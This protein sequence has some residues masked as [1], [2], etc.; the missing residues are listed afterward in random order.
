[1]L[2]TIDGFH[3]IGKSSIAKILAKELGIVYV[4]SGLI[5]RKFA[6][7]Y[8]LLFGFTDRIELTNVYK[9]M[10]IFDLNRLAGLH[11]EILRTTEITNITTVIAKERCVRSFVN[12]IILRLTCS[13]N[14]IVVGRD[15]C[16]IIWYADFKFLFHASD[17][18][19]K[20]FAKRHQNDTDKNIMRSITE[21]DGNEIKV[22]YPRECI[23]IQLED[24]PMKYIIDKL[25]MYIKKHCD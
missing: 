8:V 15:M 10:E 13:K 11:E 24:K 23:H 22:I 1:M 5:Y 4:D 19:R 9:V 17:E 2:I 14:A 20:K 21:R 7:L 16:N 12:D 18:L 3:G 6:Y 25:I